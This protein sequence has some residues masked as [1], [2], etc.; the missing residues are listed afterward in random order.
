[1]PGAPFSGINEDP[2]QYFF[3]TE[4]GALRLLLHD[5][6]E[7]SLYTN[8][9]AE[10]LRADSPTWSTSSTRS[11]WAYDLVSLTRRMLP[12]V[13]IVYTLHEYLPICHRHGQLMRTKGELCLQGR[14]G[15]ATSA[16]PIYRRSTS[17]C[18]SGFD[19]VASRARGPCSWHPSNFLLERYV[20]WG[21][22]RENPLRGLR[23]L[24]GAG[25]PRPA[26]DRPHNRLAFFGQV[27]PY[28]GVEVLLAAM[29]LAARDGARRPPVR[30]MAPTSSCS[31]TGTRPFMTLLEGSGADGNVQPG[32]VRPRR[33]FRG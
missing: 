15:A 9:F 5:L 7:K 33:P 24:A 26:E 3:F 12:D 17:S 16:S 22:P 28:K 29:Q 21:I 30:S 14:R 23:P 19:Q 27:N 18:A 6:R 11:S 13:P 20:D 8:H 25:C 10:F 4:R 2:N 1:M 32:R 31:R